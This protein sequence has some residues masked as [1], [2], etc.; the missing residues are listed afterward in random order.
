MRR[1]SAAGAA[2]A[3]A[4]RPRGHAGARCRGLAVAAASDALPSR[5]HPG[6]APRAC[7]LS[8]GVPGG[9]A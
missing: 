1:R 5:L 7:A 3:A 9:G 8:G 2:R 4:L 6:A